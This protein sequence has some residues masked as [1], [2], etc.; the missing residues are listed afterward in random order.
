M[1]SRLA[2]AAFL[3]LSLAAIGP[4]QAP[5]T[6]AKKPRVD[7]CV[8]AHTEA[9]QALKTGLLELAEWSAKQ[10]LD[11]ERARVLETVLVYDPED[12]TA[13][14]GLGYVKAKS[15]GW[16]RSAKWKEPGNKDASEL[17]EFKK[18]KA[19]VAGVFLDGMTKLLEENRRDLEP[20]LKA[21]IVGD[22]SAID[23]NDPRTKRAS[24]EAEAGGKW[25]LAE[26]AAGPPRRKQLQAWAKAAIT[27]AG[28][29]EAVEAAGNEN[30]FDI[31]WTAIVT[32]ENLRV[33]GN[34]SKDEVTKVAVLCQAAGELFAKTFDAETT[35]QTGY[36][37]PIYLIADD[38][39]K[40]DFLRK[41]KSI[42]PEEREHYAR[43]GGFNVDGT[44]VVWAADEP[45]R[46]DTAVRMIIGSFMAK[47]F[48]ISGR[49]HG[50]LYE[51]VGIHLSWFLTGTRLTWT[52]GKRKYAESGP[53]GLEEKLKKTGAD[54]FAPGFE[55]MRGK[56]RPP[57]RPLL[58]KH[59]NDLETTDMLAS[60]MLG[61]WLIEGRKDDAPRFLRAAGRNQVD[62]G[63]REAFGL[64]LNQ[65]E[66]RLVRWAK[67]NTK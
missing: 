43:L 16:E 62:E 25:V 42:K 45:A 59:V 8:T 17:G 44:Y 10:K 61:V 4:A 29:P 48:G 31:K 40:A 18:K 3:S 28:T 13:R 53:D 52:I 37:T 39:A 7:P 56:D 2:A 36:R 1:T 24:G 63:S 49:E 34:G 33:L 67:E 5:E 41:N 15:G 51:G 27:A 6:R 60:F 20:A 9:V 38:G 19:E 21:R 58:A 30:S 47:N 64:E 22:M 50:A 12:A 11:R 14:A 66:Q 23:P 32:T 57:L 35:H 65:L 26:T 54:W 46:I 55:L